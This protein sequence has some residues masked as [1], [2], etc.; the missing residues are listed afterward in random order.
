M[1]IEAPQ[2]PARKG[3]ER[4]RITLVDS[5]TRDAPKDWRSELGVSGDAYLGDERNTL[6]M[7]RHHP[8]LT[9]LLEY[10]QFALCVRLTRQPPWREIAGELLWGE[11]DDTLATAWL[12]RQRLRMRGQGVVASCAIAAAQGNSV[13]PVRAFLR[14]LKWD[15]VKRL[16]GWL[17]AYL[18]ADGPDQYLFEVGRRFLISAVARAM[19]PGC[20]VDHVLVLEGPQGI[21]KTTVARTM[22]VRP[23]W[24]AGGLPDVHNKDAALQLVGRWIVE[25][26]ELRAVRTSQVESVKAFLSTNIDTF[27]AP[28]AR[29]TG[30]VPRQCV[31]IGTTNESEYLR[32]RTGNRRFWPVRCTEIDTA[33][34]ARD[35]EHLWAEALAAFDAGEQWHLS[36]A[37]VDLAE[38]EQADRV[39]VSELE[40]QVAEYLEQQP[41][42]EITTRDVLIYCLGLDA[43]ES[44]Y[45]ERAKRL[46]TEAAEAIERAGWVKDGRRKVAG[47]RMTVYRRKGPR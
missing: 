20:Q 34:L 7:L 13:H 17:C 14:G 47:V 32:D 15:G 21:G 44:G 18:G 12:Q 5:T 26:S 33:G 22:A 1:T 4:P 38:R 16:D 11:H 35:R 2:K 24:F 42:D 36:R 45:A 27:R 23:D 28:Y 40:R 19:Q 41:K 8:E 3:G 10:D 31:F 25:I 43:S 30:Q 9:G 6:L 39:A 29:R 46:G 37:V